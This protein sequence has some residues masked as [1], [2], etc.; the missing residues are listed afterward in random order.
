MENASMFPL[1]KRAQQKFTLVLF[2]SCHPAVP[3]CIP[4]ACHHAAQWHWANDVTI[5]C[6]L[7]AALLDPWTCAE[8]I[9]MMMSSVQLWTWQNS[10]MPR[11]SRKPQCWKTPVEKYFWLTLSCLK[12][13]SLS[14]RFICADRPATKTKTLNDSAAPWSRGIASCLQLKRKIKTQLMIYE[15]VKHK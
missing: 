5:S 12:I 9:L 8:D 3:P 14:W 11:C 13:L 2:L 15:G 1:A 7:S 6:H 10:V 4:S